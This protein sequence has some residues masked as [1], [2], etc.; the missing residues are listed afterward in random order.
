MHVGSSSAR[1]ERL[2][3]RHEIRGL[4]YV[5]L[6]QANGGIVRNLS[7]EGIAVQAVAAVR[8]GQHLRL[9]F[10]LPHPRLRIEAKGEVMWAA[11]TGQCGIRFLD[12]APR[13]RRSIDEWIL[14]SLLEDI[15]AHSATHRSRTELMFRPSATVTGPLLGVSQPDETEE[16]DGLILSPAPVKVI[17]LP[18]RSDAQSIGLRAE[19]FE[20]VEAE[21]EPA[22]EVAASGVAPTSD[23][24]ELDWLSQPL[25][26]RGIAW[27][28][29]ALAV[30]AALLLFALVFLSITREAPRWPA[31]MFVGAAIFVAAFYWGFFRLFGGSSPG[32]RL[33][34]LAGYDFEDEREGEGARF[35]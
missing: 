32:A 22:A 30:L 13:M 27:A 14:G 33:A 5:M 6:D 16:E 20:A 10:E 19:G 8:A 2:R 24:A 26:S 18:G 11:P 12:L 35:R 31:A 23:T 17:E 7:H 1:K 9:R 4:T 15:A 28:V 21:A 3:H 29:N 25:S 34:R